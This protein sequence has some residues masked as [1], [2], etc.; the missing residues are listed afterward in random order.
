MKT[1]MEQKRANADVEIR[2]QL[3]DWL[4]ILSVIL[5]SM[6]GLRI[7]KIGPA[8]LLAFLWCLLHCQ[9]ICRVNRKDPFVKFWLFFLF[10]IIMGSFWGFL[11]YPQELSLPQL[12]TW[13]YFAFISLTI[14]FELRKRDL[15]YLVKMFTII[16]VFSVAWYFFLFVYSRTV[17][18]T[19]L[20]APLWFGDRRF[21]G[22]AINPNQLGLTISVYTTGCT[23]L[24]LNERVTYKTKYIVCVTIGL[25]L[26]FQT[27]CSTGYM[28]TACGIGVALWKPFSDRFLPSSKSKLTFITVAAMILI[29]FSGTLYSLF[30]KW[31]ASDSNGLGRFKIFATYPEAFWKSP[32]IGL[33]PGGHARG[34]TY[35]FHNTYLEVLA[36]GGILGGI[37]FLSLSYYLF[38]IGINSSLFF[39]I[40]TTLYVFGLAGFAMRQLIYWTMLSI[41]YLIAIKSNENGNLMKR[42]N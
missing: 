6:T 22:G 34:G 29:V 11:F 14:L 9:S 17:S 23:W 7:W 40:M 2:I 16:C 13:I 4:L 18:K 28:S 36:A 26:L 33:G 39:S 25:F 41:T 31:V 5:A 1:I 12:L 3:K 35:E 19:F 10:A 27:E 20:G 8:E 24:L 32:F 42:I 21:T 37:A 38:K 30:I 15:N